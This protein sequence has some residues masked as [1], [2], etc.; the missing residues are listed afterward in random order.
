MDIRLRYKELKKLAEKKRYLSLR[1]FIAVYSILVICISC[2]LSYAAVFFITPL[3]VKGDITMEISMAMCITALIITILLSGAI[4]WHGS[5]IIVNPVFRIISGMKKVASG[6]FKVQLSSN[7]KKIYNHYNEIDVL[8]DN[9]NKMVEELNG[10]EY[11][12]KDFIG[13]VSHEIR[14]PV[15]AIAGFS[16]I[17]ADGGISKEEELEYLQYIHEEAGRLSRLCDSMLHMSRLDNQVIVSQKEVIKV[18]EQIR[19]AVIVLEQKWVEKDISFDIN[20][21]K[22]TVES[23]YDMLLQVWINLIDN[24]IKYSSDRDVI[25]ISTE[26]DSKYL[27]VII[28][29]QG[30]SIN[31]EKLDK[32]FDKFYQCEESH[33]HKGTGLGL[34]IVKRILQ[35]LDGT[36]ECVSSKGRGTTMKV[37]LPVK[38]SI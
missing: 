24:A 8:K 9:F 23:N 1:L 4:I 17:L 38:N 25:K 14:T 15:A 12:Q 10:M 33:K 3:L 27:R 13:N 34:S 21:C 26:L 11:M 29:D 37:T 5:L 2:V 30:I 19:K 35:L 22:C 6:D 16:E 31:E 28:D 20:L 32:I 18:D 7:N 36:I